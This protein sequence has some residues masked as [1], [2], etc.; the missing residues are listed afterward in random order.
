MKTLSSINT[1]ILKLNKALPNY[2]LLEVMWMHLQLLFLFSDKI[3]S[4]FLTL[5]Y[6]EDNEGAIL[7]PKCQLGSVRTEGHAPHSLF[8][9]AASDQGMVSKAPQPAP[10]GR[11]S[12][13][14]LFLTAQDLG[15]IK[16][17]PKGLTQ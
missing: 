11:E 9:I 7:H 1:N 6:S 13:R 4:G 3:P 12:R 15:V 16:R 5:P 17:N 10:E 2:H 8:H 14:G